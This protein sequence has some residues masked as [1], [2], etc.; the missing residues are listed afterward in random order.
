MTEIAVNV[1]PLIGP[2]VKVEIE[3]DITVNTFKTKLCS[4]KI[5]GTIAP[6]HLSFSQTKLENTKK[7]SDY[8][9]QNGSIVHILPGKRPL[10]ARPGISESRN[11]EIDATNIA[12]EQ[13]ITG[14]DSPN[15]ST[16]GNSFHQLP[17]CERWKYDEVIS[18]NMYLDQKVEGRV[19]QN[20]I[21]DSI[22]RRNMFGKYTGHIKAEYKRAQRERNKKVLNIYKT[23]VIGK[24]LGNQTWKEAKDLKKEIE[25]AWL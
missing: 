25:Q 2:D 13:S 9:I 23:K 7:L 10:T 19:G 5:S 20:E 16:E 24:N 3:K 6:H 15:Q 12:L 8:N 18:T 14:E 22:E 4:L 11:L 21:M 1:R 17:L